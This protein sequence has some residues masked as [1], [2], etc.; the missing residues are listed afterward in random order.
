MKFDVSFEVW[1]EQPFFVPRSRDDPKSLSGFQHL[2]TTVP[3][4]SRT[5]RD[6]LIELID[7]ASTRVFVC[8]FLIGGE[9]VRDALRRAV[10]RLRGHVYVI[11]ALDEKSLQRS[12]AQELDEIDPEAL[13]R[14]RKSF[15]ALTWHGVYVR[16]AENC[17]AKFCIVDDRVALLGSANFDPNGLNLE[18]RGT[19]ACGELGLVLDSPAR[20]AG[21]AALF[22]HIWRCGCNR[23]APPLRDGYR[24]NR[25]SRVNDPVPTVPED[26]DGVVWT[27]FESTAILAGIQRV[28]AAAQHNL[29]LASY[30]FT[31]M[32]ARPTLLLNA[33]AAARKRGVQIE[34]L[35]RDRAR[36][37]HEI[38]SLLNIG[39]E[40]RA[41]RENH[42]K[43]A[44]ADGREG[45][46][47]SANF[48]GQH[49][50]TDGVETG[51]RLRPEE[52]GEL[53][54]WHDQIWRETPSQVR[55]WSTPEA[56]AQAMPAIRHEIPPFVGGALSIAGDRDALS[57]CAS[58]LEGPCLLVC[59]GDG[60][61][62]RSVR[63]VGFDEVVRLEPSGHAMK[64][65]GVGR[66]DSMFLPLPR[67]MATSQLGAS[68]GWLPLGLEVNLT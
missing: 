1:R 18:Q 43:Y 9:E 48:D 25:V 20:V 8:S 46:L 68:R 64:A 60:T 39:V 17:H 23:E 26:A 45:L 10:R 44:L 14:E 56:F 67:L 30:S 36:D 63:L 42:A 21:L 66:G 7:S 15:E 33:L 12:L 47:F 28:V 51:V 53:A 27:G 5:I 65:F 55:R 38:S 19:I 49:G 13:A 22:R 4:R 35:L 59:D 29:V 58:I 52:A 37:L 61:V 2:K 54:R 24:L 3:G 11:T 57:Q 62:A 31:G 32:S 50:L 16:G 6:A 41:N 34:M 40:V